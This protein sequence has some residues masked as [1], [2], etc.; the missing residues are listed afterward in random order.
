MRKA[1]DEYGKQLVFRDS[2]HFAIKLLRAVRE[3]Y[4]QHT[5]S[6]KDNVYLN[7]GLWD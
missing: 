2:S 1:K 5:W 4:K 7:S 6:A 3:D